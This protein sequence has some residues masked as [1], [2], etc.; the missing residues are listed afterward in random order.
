M[1][2]RRT[3]PLDQAGDNRDAV[4]A[5][6]RRTM[7]DAGIGAEYHDK[8]FMDYDVVS[9]T[10]A[11]VVREKFL[12]TWP[13][14]LREGRGVNI[15]GA[16]IRVG[17]LHMMMARAAHLAGS[18]VYVT[19][20]SSLARGLHGDGGDDFLDEMIN[21]DIL[22]LRRFQALGKITIASWHVGAVESLIED[23]LSEGRAVYPWM[24]HD[25]GDAPDPPWWSAYLRARLNE[26]NQT[27]EVAG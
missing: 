22:F 25:P 21:L 17:G 27:V 2:R 5:E 3:R 8:R 18:N 24:E 23:R 26:R 12:E 19:D 15:I 20:L 11:E 1:V 13:F 9:N 10:D 6:V 14:T 4:E 7:A 16:S